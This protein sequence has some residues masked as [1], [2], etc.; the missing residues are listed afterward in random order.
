MIVFH[1][2][3]LQPNLRDPVAVNGVNV[4]WFARV[5]RLK[6]EL[7]AFNFNRRHNSSRWR[8]GFVFQR[9]EDAFENP[10]AVVAA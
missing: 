2:N 3:G 10:L 5:R 6:P 4:R 8:D 9:R 7:V 1:R